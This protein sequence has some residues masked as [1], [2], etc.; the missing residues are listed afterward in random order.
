MQYSR[1]NLILNALVALPFLT[2]LGLAIWFARKANLEQ[3]QLDVSPAD[4]VSK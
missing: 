4:K 2:V 3:R 1:R